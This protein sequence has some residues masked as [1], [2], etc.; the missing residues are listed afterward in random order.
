MI[1]EALEAMAEVQ[2]MLGVRSA[3]NTG[4][5]RHVHGHRQS[6]HISDVTTLCSYPSGELALE[7][8]AQPAL[9]RVTGEDVR[10]HQGRE[11]EVPVAHI[12]TPVV[13]TS[14]HF[15]SLMHDPC[16]TPP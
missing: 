1:V 6:T 12:Y 10:E 11:P 3:A 13:R 9:L 4:T 2:A 5:S 7:P 16:P 8:S 14:E 15:V